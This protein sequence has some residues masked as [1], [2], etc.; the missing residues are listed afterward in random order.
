M[1]KRVCRRSV[2]CVS[3]LKWKMEPAGFFLAIGAGQ[4]TLKKVPAPQRMRKEPMEIALLIVELVI[5][6]AALWIAF[7]TWRNSRQD[8]E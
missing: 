4:M 2:A 1:S 3:G 7:L 5:A 6:A 8:D